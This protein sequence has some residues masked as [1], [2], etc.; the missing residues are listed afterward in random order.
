MKNSFEEI[1]LLRA[2]KR[3][4][5]NAFEAL[6][7]SH[8]KRLYNFLFSLL[9]S[10]EDAEEIL[11]ETF[12]KMWE[13]RMFFDENYPFQALLFKIA[14]NSFLDH[15]RKKVNKAVFDSEFDLSA[16]LSENST[17]DYVLYWETK[18]IIKKIIDG[19]PP[20]RRQIFLMQKIEGLSRLEIAQQLNI[21]IITV[22][23]QLLKA[24][25]FF[26]EEFQKYNM[27]L[28]LLF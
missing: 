17:D 21:S 11:Q 3:G 8:H 4:D 5:T 15:S 9:K 25:K 10:K 26:K 24:N 22:D 2:F 12:V 1:E 14:R 23:S 13:N 20:K 16:R 6:F 7:K 27:L 28:F 19:L 18:D